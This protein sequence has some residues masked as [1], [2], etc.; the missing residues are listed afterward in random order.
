MPKI[1]TYRQQVGFEAGQLGPRLSGAAASQVGSA[2]ANLGK[3]VTNVANI[4]AEFEKARQDQEANDLYNN[5]NAQATEELYKIIQDE[6]Y[7]DIPSMTQAFDTAAKGFIDSSITQNNKLSSRQKNSL[8][9]SMTKRFNLLRVDGLK[10]ANIRQGVDSQIAYNSSFDAELATA[11]ANPPMVEMLAA[12]HDQMSIEQAKLGI[13][14]K[15]GNDFRVAAYKEIM[16]N[17]ANNDSTSLNVLED[18]YDAIMKGQGE[19]STLDSDER[20]LVASQLSSRID[21]LKDEVVDE[22]LGN[23]EVLT[24]SMGFAQ[25]Q[26]ERENFF[27]Q[28]EAEIAKL[29]SL[30]QNAEAEKASIGFSAYKRGL[31]AGD[32]LAFATNADITNTLN[33]SRQSIVDAVGTEEILV[34]QKEHEALV[35]VSEQI[36]KARTE[37]PVSFIQSHFQRVHNRQPTVEQL[38]QK[39]RTMGIDEGD[40]KILSTNQAT[41]AVETIG[42]AMASGDPMQVVEVFKSI[43]GVQSHGGKVMRQLTANGMPLAAQF[44][45][46]QPNSAINK[47]LMK[48]TSP[49]GLKI[50]VTKNNMTMARQTVAADPTMQKFI[51]SIG[52]RMYSDFQGVEMLSSGV[53]TPEL[54]A[55]RDNMVDM[56]TQTALFLMQ[57][58]N[59]FF[60]DESVADSGEFAKYAKEAV[61]IISDRYSFTDINDSVLRLPRH[62]EQAAPVIAE[63][64]DIDVFMLNKDRI[65]Y[66]T[67]SGFSID[68][69]EFEKERE[70]Y[71]ER[72][73]SNYG[74]MTRNGERD[75]I[76][77]D[78]F[79]GAVLI[80][81]RDDDGNP[82]IEPMTI[83]FQ[84]AIQLNNQF[85]A[86]A[87]DRLVA[88]RQKIEGFIR[89]L[90]PP[91]SDFEK[92]YIRQFE[93][94]SAILEQ[95]INDMRRRSAE[96]SKSR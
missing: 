78:E 47:T 58:K 37:D 39:Q 72:V 29:A 71:L 44:V 22:T 23:L 27:S 5:L 1:P 42:E 46:N 13:K 43:P 3:A 4:A 12:K 31:D 85:G 14:T 94:K 55:F 86:P 73:R 69:P 28:G 49:D 56:V 57:E 40:I 7:R 15:D 6:R 80:K 30:G 48:A 95:S 65:H 87:M 16:F 45:A 60:S 36:V 50:N 21:Y 88:E 79:G 91:K 20:S 76:I 96:R 10:A 53:D 81:T 74:V 34:R 35:Q 11:I 51:N 77:V 66:E 90:S 62:L 67:S 25:T 89:D 75:A 83:N 59:G 9:S 32:N 26:Q 92:D 18:T 2:Y 70:L 38:I 61:S 63:G 82:A 8:R 33:Q 54:K 64:I 93:E 52:G 24:T 17:K 84:N 19:Y 68:S 41:S